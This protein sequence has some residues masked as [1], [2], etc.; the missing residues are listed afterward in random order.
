MDGVLCDAGSLNKTPSEVVSD[1]LDG[2]VID[3]LSATLQ[4]SSRPF[5]L[6]L[7]LQKILHLSAGFIIL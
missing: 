1:S 7:H 2:H 3:H 6:S 5:D 4:A